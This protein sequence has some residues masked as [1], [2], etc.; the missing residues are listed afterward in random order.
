MTVMDEKRG[1]TPAPGDPIH[2]D[3]L[4][5]A[6]ALAIAVADRSTTPAAEA[7]SDACVSLSPEHETALFV[8]TSTRERLPALDDLAFER[9]RRRVHAAPPL[10]R[11][12][13]PTAA[14]PTRR[15]F[16]RFA[17]AAVGLAASLAAVW[18]LVREANEPPDA[19]GAAVTQS[20]VTQYVTQS[21]V[22]QYAALFTTPFTRDERPLARI[23][24]M[25]ARHQANR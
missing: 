5:A 7:Q 13:A 22:T 4:H 9:V 23:E 24:R 25:L 19:P 14:R 1:P 17:T 16:V 18:L 6:A 11:T 12:A 2:E 15:P 20:S 3:E 10:A 21:S 8:S